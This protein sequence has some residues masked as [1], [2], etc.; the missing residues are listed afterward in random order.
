MQRKV[1]ALNQKWANKGCQ[2]HRIR[3]GINTGFVTVGNMGGARR[4]DFT[5]SG[6]E[7]NK[8]QRFESNAPPGGIISGKKTYVLARE[9]LPADIQNRFTGKPISVK[10]LIN[11]LKYS[12]SG[13]WTN[14]RAKILGDGGYLASGL[15][16]WLF[17]L[18]FLFLAAPC[19]FEL[20]S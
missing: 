16:G 17:H 6:S 20:Q 19:A 3:V 11:R 4:M 13:K 15:D 7:V 14:L 1:R 10:I 8:A 18:F 12:R 2:S 9:S 5:V